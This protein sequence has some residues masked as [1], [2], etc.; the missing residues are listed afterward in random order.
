MFPGRPKYRIGTVCK[1]VG[2]SR[3]TLNGWI[4]QGYAMGLSVPESS[5]GK[6]RPFTFE[7][8]VRVAVFARFRDMGIDKK[9]ADDAAKNA[10]MASAGGRVPDIT[11]FPVY[12]LQTKTYQ[13]S[14]STHIVP[15]T[16]IDMALRSEELLVALPLTTIAEKLLA[17]LNALEDDTA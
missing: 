12:L 13:G 5:K 10:Y 4:N 2:I 11:G 1:V 7:D 14:F 8:V 17:K 9:L 6:F 15:A 16:T 3:S